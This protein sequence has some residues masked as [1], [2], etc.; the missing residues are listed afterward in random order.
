MSMTAEKYSMRLTPRSIWHWLRHE[1]I[2]QLRI[3]LYDNGQWYILWDPERNYAK[4]YLYHLGE[5][6]RRAYS[7]PV[8]VENPK[9]VRR[10]HIF[11]NLFTYFS[12]KEFHFQIININIAQCLSWQ[13]LAIWLTDKNNPRNRI[14]VPGK[15]NVADKSFH[16][17]INWKQ[18]HGKTWT[19]IAK[20][21]T[22]CCSCMRGSTSHCSINHDMF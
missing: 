17:K 4:I 12:C 19:C 14:F 6:T 16:L 21:S 3:T 13:I 7:I 9:N 5:K 20:W 2:D 18:R 15:W 8:A 1:H 10:C 11:I 22:S